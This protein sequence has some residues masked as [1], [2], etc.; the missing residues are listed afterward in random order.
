MLTIASNDPAN[1][2]VTVP[3]SGS[4]A[5]VS[6]AAV[7]LILDRSGSMA[8]A[9]TG[10]TRM[11]AL[12]SA[13]SMFAELVVPGSGFSMGSVQFDTTEAVLTP[14][15]AFDATQQSAIIAGA[16][17]LFPRNLTSIGGGLQ[18]GQTSLSASTM[19]RNVAIVFTDGY[20]NTPPMIAAV[21]P[22]VLSAGTEVYAVGLGD[23][24]YLSVAALQQLAASSNGKFFQT[25]DPLVLRKQFVEIVADA[26][27]QNMAAD[28]I[29]TLQQG[30]SVSVP[31][32]I[33]SCESRI[34]FVLL[35]EDPTA[36]IQ[37][38]VRAPDG[39]TFGGGSGANNQLVRYVQSP[40]YR[41]LQIA[42]PP[43]PNG[44]IGP[45]QLG[46]WQMLLNPVSISGGTTR[47]S[48][49]VLVESELQI[50]AQVQST[51]TGA[52]MR[53]LAL[54]THLGSPINNAHVN[55]ELTTPLTSLS[56]LS[57]P[58]V[59]HRAVAADRHHIPAALQILTK[60]RAT[61]YEMH[62]EKREY[63]VQ[64]PTPQ[65]DGVYHAAV[66]ATGT[67]CGGA[68]ERYWSTSF[69]VGPRLK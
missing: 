3:L 6:P 5:V 53:L 17:S 47:A 29:F 61:R 18:L 41:F 2:S 56:H 23:P 40:G 8:T 11:T 25:T 59:R 52:P 9:I 46:Q 63:V 13:V 60:T 15:A 68:F 35:W 24:A 27:R 28:P 69:Y 30:V 67:A 16:N 21:E 4:G 14:L 62:F 50:A 7:E 34:S 12:Q 43:G 57:T 55:V 20:E 33:T 64:F 32:N 66:T 49:N 48:T 58:I 51:T 10:G 54:L 19:P 44:T 37:F 31:V 38:S 45:L 39:T 65:V 36:Q 1:P 26:F 42:L 22:A